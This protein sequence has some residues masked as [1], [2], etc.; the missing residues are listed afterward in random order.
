MINQKLQVTVKDSAT[1][2]QAAEWCQLNHIDYNIEYWGWPG[3]KIYKFV[4]ENH[5]D[6]VNF[7][8]KWV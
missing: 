1:A 4:F 5:Q 7:S 3:S 2:H 8:L 6:L